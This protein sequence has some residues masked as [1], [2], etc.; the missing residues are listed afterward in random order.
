MERDVGR[1]LATY[2]IEEDMGRFTIDRLGLET[3]FVQS[4][5]YRIGEDDPLSAEIDIRYVIS[6]G[7]KEWQTRTETR[8]IMPNVESRISTVSSNRRARTLSTSP[9]SSTMARRTTAGTSRW[10][11]GCS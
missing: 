11:V 3:D 10:P 8:T 2:H 1:G 7:R 5:A 4:E 6:I 9:A